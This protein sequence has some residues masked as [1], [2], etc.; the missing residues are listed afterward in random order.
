MGINGNKWHKKREF[1]H[2]WG[3][4]YVIMVL[5]KNEGETFVKRLPFCYFWR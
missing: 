1:G 4:Q 3:F 5:L 2:A